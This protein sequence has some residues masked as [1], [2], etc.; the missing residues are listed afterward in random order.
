MAAE[1]F[2]TKLKE[3]RAASG[4]TQPQLAEKAGFTKSGIADLESGRRKPS[5]A[6]VLAIAA[7]LGV[8]CEAFQMKPAEEEKPVK[9]A[10]KGKKK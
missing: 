5:W 2:S 9:P 4:M 8:S 1:D 7:A 6:T 3:L 10:K